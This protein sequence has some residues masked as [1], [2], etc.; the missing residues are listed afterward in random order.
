MQF[1]RQIRSFVRRGRVPQTQMQALS[2]QWQ[3]HVLGN[4]PYHLDAIFQRSAHRVLEIGFGMGHAL[5]TQARQNPQSDFLGI[6]VHRPG[7]ATVLKQI[8]ADSLTNIRLCCGDATEILKQ[9][10]SDHSFDLIQIFFP[11]PWQKR[12]HH[13]RRLIQP[14]FAALLLQKLKIG[15]M[16]HLATDWEDYAHHILKVL[17]EAPGFKNLA[18][19]NQFSPRPAERP[20]TKFE[21]RGQSL[22][23]GVWDLIFSRIE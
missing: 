22:G 4:G 14:E 13:K 9:Q 16:L 10:I 20:L 17:T 2:T 21:K 8:G 15:G 3:H 6:E 19:D 23:H 18:G 1:T 11:D 5:L 12:R 7:I